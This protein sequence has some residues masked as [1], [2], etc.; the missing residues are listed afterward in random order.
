MEDI[1]ASIRRIIADAPPEN[2][3]IG[4]EGET[5]AGRFAV[6]EITTIPLVGP[7][8]PLAP[9]ADPSDRDLDICFVADTTAEREGFA[10]W[11]EDPDSSDAVPAS[12]RRAQLLTIA[13]QF[14][15]IRLDSKLWDGEPDARAA[16]S[17]PVIGIAA[18]PQPLQFLVL[19]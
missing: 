16:T 5:I 18:E 1:L 12:S 10:R 11:L 2:L 15:R 4:I 17:W 19:D 7:R 3:E 6:V 9:E 13:G 14:R 8:L